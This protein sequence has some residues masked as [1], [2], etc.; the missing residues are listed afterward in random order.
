[1]ATIEEAIEAGALERFELPDFELR[2]PER[3]LYV[4]PEFGDWAD[5]TQELHDK[6]FAI[7]RRTLFEHLLLTLCEFR[8]AKHPHAGDLRRLMPTKKGLWKMHS[9]GL[10]L[11]G[12]CP[13][14][15]TFTVVT[16]ALESE[17]KADKKLNDKKAQEVEA[18]IKKHA[19]TQ[20]ILRGDVLA[21]FPHKN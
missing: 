7:G 20:T 14:K 15:H 6:K 19:L 21:V 12:W 13:G 18:F 3:P 16:G 17:T 8:C 11:Y 1:M 9:P 2:L 4:T 10:R 5:G